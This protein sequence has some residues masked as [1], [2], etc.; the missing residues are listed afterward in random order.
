MFSVQKLVD[1]NLKLLFGNNKSV[2][3]E[4]LP[5]PLPGTPNTPAKDP[6]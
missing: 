2:D 3:D 5:T 1:E 6:N 4:I